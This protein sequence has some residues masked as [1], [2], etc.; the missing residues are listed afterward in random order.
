MLNDE[1][2]TAY[3]AVVSKLLVIAPYSADGSYRHSG[4]QTGEKP[5]QNRSA[6]ES[7]GGL[8]GR[9]SPFGRWSSANHSN[10]VSKAV[11]TS[12]AFVASG[13]E[14]KVSFRPGIFGIN[15]QGKHLEIRR[16]RM[17]RIGE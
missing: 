16:P 17:V 3:A 9:V 14:P 12:A 10:K 15:N 13:T 4:V 1:L 8:L 11:I 7:S 6:D 2:V 5:R